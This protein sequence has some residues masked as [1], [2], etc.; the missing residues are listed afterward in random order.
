M[1]AFPVIS[2]RPFITG[3]ESQELVVAQQIY[4]AFHNYR[5]VYL[6]D[7]GISEQKI[8]AMFRQVSQSPW[9]C[10]AYVLTGD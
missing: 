7:F 1:P 8:N 4:D 9:H 5:W 2:F 10:L 6:K 3:T